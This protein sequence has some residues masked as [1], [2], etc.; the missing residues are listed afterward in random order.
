MSRTAILLASLLLISPSLLAQGMGSFLPSKVAAKAAKLLASIDAY[1]AAI[2]SRRGAAREGQLRA[3]AAAV[4]AYA[5][6]AATRSSGTPWAKP[7]GSGRAADPSAAFATARAKA[8]AAAGE[9]LALGEGFAPLVSR[10]GAEDAL[11]ALILSSGIGE[12]T[13]VKLDQFLARKARGFG[14]LFPEAQELAALLRASGAAGAREAAAA[15]AHR[16]DESVASYLVASK[17]RLLARFPAAEEPIARLEAALAAHRAWVA[18]SAVAA[19]PGDLVS[20]TIED[21]KALAGGIDA[22][23]SLGLGRASGLLAAMREGDGRDIAAGEAARRL[24]ELWDRSPAARRRDLASLCSQGES[25][26]ALFSLAASEGGGQAN[27]RHSLRETPAPPASPGL[28]ALE[29]MSALNGIEIAIADEESSPRGAEPALLF[30][31]RPALASI[32]KRELRYANLYAEAARRIEALYAQAAE[33]AQARLEASA[34]V[35]KAA[36]RA[37]GSSAVSILVRSIDID[38]PPERPGRRIAFFATATDASGFSVSF[39]LGAELSGAVYAV[40]FSRAAGLDSAA[41]PKALMMKYGQFAVSAYDP[42][43]MRGALVIDVFPDSE[44]PARLAEGDLELAL[45]GAWRP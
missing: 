37:L 15:M 8:K 43:G 42:E 45:L 30:L 18:A 17:A 4:E 38:A 32:A 20:A 9:E 39:P 44:D 5:L 34:A 6:I 26:M 33:G 13:A 7:D 22:V 25:A 14:R 36:A 1:S 40:A 27:Q 21:R 35:S 24:A 12:K 10:G 29:A 11:G 16:G 3:E 23:L 28:P 2:D 31:E 41:D 19:Y